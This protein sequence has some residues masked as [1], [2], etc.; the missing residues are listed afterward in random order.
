MELKKGYAYIPVADFDKAAK[1]YKD[2]LGFEL[3]FSDKLYRELHSPS[4]ICIMLIDRRGDVNSHM[5]YDTGPQAAFGFT[6]DDIESIHEDFIAKGLN[7]R[8]I[9]D[10]QGKSFGFEDLDGNIIELWE[11]AK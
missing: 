4:G 7:P 10:Y 11:V 9:S 6:V 3:V 5:M 1:W 2:I 8:K